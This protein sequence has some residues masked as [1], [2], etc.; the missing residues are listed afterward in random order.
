MLDTFAL[1]NIT[2]LNVYLCQY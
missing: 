1:I 2:N